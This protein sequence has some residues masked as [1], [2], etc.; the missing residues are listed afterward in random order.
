MRVFMVVV[1]VSVLVL[2][3]WANNTNDAGAGQAGATSITTPTTS[4]GI[5]QNPEF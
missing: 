4:N 1:F 3:A 2:A 5:W